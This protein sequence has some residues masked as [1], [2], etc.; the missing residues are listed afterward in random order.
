M[1]MATVL[2]INITPGP[3]MLFCLNQSRLYGPKEGM[4]AV[5]GVELGVLVYL[6]L[7]M[8]GLGI[9]FEKSPALYKMIQFA[10]MLYLLYLA[11]V[12]WPA[13]N[14]N[15]SDDLSLKT[16][17]NQNIK[18]GKKTFL[19]G[20]LINMTNPKIALF[21]IGLMPQFVMSGGNSGYMTFLLYGMIF[22]VG[23]IVINTSVVLLSGN[24][25]NII[26]EG[27]MNFVAYLPS[28]IFVLIVLNVF[29]DFI[30]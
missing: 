24:W 29:R 20:F 11:Y 28:I 12:S 14:N 17:N 1:F 19:K 7:V 6:L 21:F 2:L 10:G 4:K 18:N 16:T 3:A 22:S 8:F 15:I 27:K 23:G 30:K 13:K 9:F 25:L 26:K 5:A